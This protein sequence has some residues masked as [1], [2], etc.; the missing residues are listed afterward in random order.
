MPA[1]WPPFLWAGGR[2]TGSVLPTRQLPGTQVDVGLL[3]I[4]ARRDCPFHPHQLAPAGLVSVA[5]I[6]TSRWTA[7]SCYAALCSPDLPPV[8]PFGPCTSGGLACFTSGIIGERRSGVGA[9]VQEAGSE[10]V[11][12]EPR[13]RHRGPAAGYETL[14]N[15][16]K[17]RAGEYSGSLNRR[18]QPFPCWRVFM[19]SLAPDGNSSALTS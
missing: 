15:T 5:L 18:R 4:A 13:I 9:P 16:A 19:S 12:S 11:V 3:G 6:L 2:P 17:L 14:F 1:P 8:R 7:V 10:R